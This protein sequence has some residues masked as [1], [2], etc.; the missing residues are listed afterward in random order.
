M[1]TKDELEGLFTKTSAVNQTLNVSLYIN[2]NYFPNTNFEYW[3]SSPLA[4]NSSSA[5]YVD[6][7]GGSSY[8]YSKN[9]N[10]FVRLVR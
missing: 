7:Y 6:F 8:G 3:S 5:W 4:L 9:V 1:P 10:N 2:A